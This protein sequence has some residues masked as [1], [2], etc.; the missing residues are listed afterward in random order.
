[1]SFVFYLRYMKF[2]GDL[3]TKKPGENI[4]GFPLLVGIYTLLRQSNTGSV[5]V[6]IDTLCQYAKVAALAK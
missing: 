6:F 5:E 1:M 4:D 2:L 3:I